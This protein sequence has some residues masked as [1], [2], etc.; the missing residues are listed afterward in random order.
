[1]EEQR[2]ASHSEFVKTVDKYLCHEP[3]KIC[4]KAIDVTTA[5]TPLPEVFEWRK[6]V[7]V[8]DS[9]SSTETSD[10]V[11]KKCSRA[12]KRDKQ[13]Y[14]TTPFDLFTDH[15]RIQHDVVH[16]ITT[17]MRS[18]KLKHK[19]KPSVEPMWQHFDTYG[20]AITKSKEMTPESKHSK[21]MTGVQVIE[22]YNNVY[23]KFNVLSKD[24][25]KHA[26]RFTENTRVLGEKQ[27][28]RRTSSITELQQEKPSLPLIL[29]MSQKKIIIHHTLIERDYVMPISSREIVQPVKFLSIPRIK[30]G[31]QSNSLRR[32]SAESTGVSSFKNVPSEIEEKLRTQFQSHINRRENSCNRSSSLL[33][34]KSLADDA[35]CQ[36]SEKDCLCSIQHHSDGPPLSKKSDA[37][38]TNLHA[39]SKSSYKSVERK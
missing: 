18:R 14:T 26:K 30:A 6:P 2:R 32:L 7:S 4:S 36:S 11:V 39:S 5:R 25:Q 31:I 12:N 19:Q 20:K 13:V 21:L 10:T 8:T 1:M 3:N 35:N 28:L 38:I 22:S 17:K 24:T 27:L 16:S 23:D 15:D 34:T 9:V 29:P 37:K 33:N